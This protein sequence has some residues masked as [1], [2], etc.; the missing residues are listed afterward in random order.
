[1]GGVRLRRSGDLLYRVKKL[2]KSGIFEEPPWLEALE[3]VPPLEMPKRPRPRPLRFP[4]S[5]MEMQYIKNNPKVL[6][7][8]VRLNGPEP[9]VP[10]QFVWRQLE[11]MRERGLSKAEAAS[12]VHEEFNARGIG[13]PDPKTKSAVEQMQ[14]QETRELEAAM[15]RLHGR[16]SQAGGAA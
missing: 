16:T 14:I 8:P 15:K 2:L 13:V 3:R 1:M 9:S 5:Q 7:I 12:V 6:S 10:R 4:E 11:L